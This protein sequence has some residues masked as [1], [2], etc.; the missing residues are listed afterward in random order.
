MIIAE[1][2]ITMMIYS[3]VYLKANKKINVISICKVKKIFLIKNIWNKTIK[4]N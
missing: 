2:N 3:I 1:Q 4:F